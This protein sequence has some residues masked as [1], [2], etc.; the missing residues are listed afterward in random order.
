MPLSFNFYHDSALT[1]PITT[2]NPLTALQDAAGGLGPVDKVIY[3]GS[4][5]TGNQLQAVSDPGT[6]PVEIVVVDSDAGSGAPATEIR[7][8]LSSGG[9]DSAT[10]G[11]ALALSHTLLSGVGNAVPIHVR[12]TS[13]VG[14]P[15]VYTDITLETNSVDEGI[16]P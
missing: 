8:A 12:R 2:G 9:L 5:L 1:E 14:T 7:L 15:G 16:A 3:L 11:A 13:A 4:T 6:D 10:P